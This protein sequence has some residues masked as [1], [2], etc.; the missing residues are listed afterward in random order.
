MQTEMESMGNRYLTDYKTDTEVIDDLIS[1]CEECKKQGIEVKIVIPPWLDRFYDE[2]S[3]YG[4]YDMDEYKSIL[5]EYVDIYDFEYKD[6]P[7]NS[8][9]D[10]FSDLSHFH[11]YTYEEY[12]DEVIYGK[13]KYSRLWKNGYIVEE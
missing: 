3:S 11:N 9:F 12:A 6:C 7:L 2:L 1:I 10:D 5:S 4:S 13:I 8:R